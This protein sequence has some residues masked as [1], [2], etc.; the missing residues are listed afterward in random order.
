MIA[1]FHKAPGH[2]IVIDKD[3]VDHD[4]TIS[5]RAKGILTYLMGRPET[6]SPNIREI[7]AHASDKVGSVKA[8]I[9]ELKRA[10]YVQITRL[11][12]AES[13]KWIG[14]D[15]YVTDDP[16]KPKVENKLSG[17]S[18]KVKNQLSGKTPKV[19]NKLSAQS[20]QAGGSAPPP[21]EAGSRTAESQKTVLRKIDFVIKKEG[22]RK[23]EREKKREK[24][25]KE[26]RARAEKMKN[27]LQFTEERDLSACDAQAGAPAT[28]QARHA[29]L[30]EQARQLREEG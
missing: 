17:E 4:T 26:E 5:F 23:K 20:P 21:T 29:R 19:E 11:R 8:G 22:P 25:E 6:W 10:G 14:W 13:Q 9:K 7:A 16:S 28:E 27:L 12:D 3:M 18:P 15:W 30:Q 1:K 24:E 2:F